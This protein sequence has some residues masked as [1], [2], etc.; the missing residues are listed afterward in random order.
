MIPMQ[1]SG[2]SLPLRSLSTIS[3]KNIHI[4]KVTGQDP[5]NQA[6]SVF[7]KLEGQEKEDKGKVALKKELT[8]THPNIA[9][10]IKAMNITNR[11]VVY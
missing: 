10:F 6:V 7:Q 8:A 9:L 3:R 4:T 2:G 5:T 11:N 1:G